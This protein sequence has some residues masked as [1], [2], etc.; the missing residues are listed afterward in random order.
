MKVYQCDRCKEIFTPRKL[1]H[2]E[3]YLTRKRSVDIDLCP[4]CLQ[5][6]HEWLLQKGAYERN[7]EK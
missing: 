1:D 5:G 7:T 2:G 6:L 3:I 4:A